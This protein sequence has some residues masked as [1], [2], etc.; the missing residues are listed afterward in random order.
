LYPVVE[1][2]GVVRRLGFYVFYIF[3]SQMAATFSALRA[4]R[5]LSPLRLVVLISV[6]D[7]I[8]PRAYYEPKDKVNLKNP[9]TS[10]GF[11]HATSRFVVHGA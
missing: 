1:A 11:E 4:Y 10:S 7:P 8:K 6:K 2:I 9:V 5:A 3:G